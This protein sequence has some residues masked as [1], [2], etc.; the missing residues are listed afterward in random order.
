[1]GQAIAATVVRELDD[2]FA[3]RFD[4]SLDARVRMIRAFYAGDYADAFQGVRALPVSRAIVARI[5]G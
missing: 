1:M 4:E 3:V 2:G 5:F